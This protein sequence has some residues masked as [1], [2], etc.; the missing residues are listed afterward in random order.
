VD[1]RTVRV[2]IVAALC[3][4]AVGIAA[5][6]LDSAQDTGGGF[7]PGNAGGP[8]G[9]ERSG[10]SIV[11]LN[12]RGSGSF[13]PKGAAAYGGCIEFLRSLE[14]L[15]GALA[16]VIGIGAVIT[17]RHNVAVALA[18]LI[19]FGMPAMV[20]YLFL[21]ACPGETADPGL[22]PEGGGNASAPQGGGMP[23]AGSGTNPAPPS[24]V[25][26]AVLGVLLLAAAIVI[27][28][29]TGDDEVE[30]DQPDE[31]TTDE[32]A[33][34]A[35]GAVAGAAA[36]RIDAAGDVDNEV[37]R[38]WREMVQLL[39]VEN[40]DATTPGEFADAAVAAGMER[41]DVAE[42]TDLFEAVRYGGFDPTADREGRAVDALR[43]I[44]DEYA[45]D[46]AGW[47][48]EDDDE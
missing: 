46:D 9:G 15:L 27:A 5:A 22:I 7:G 18:M 8:G 38:A 10:D 32:E 11:D 4:L 34:E 13:L 48:P 26:L 44:E 12:D 35:I 1:R 2:A 28:R 6:T 21:A 30:L 47:G 42:L 16:V 37:Y 36:D 31:P 24:L 40:P 41:D 3:I 39:A 45:G 43:R 17:F 33:V 25:V 23:G 14:F 20:L 29:S 19:A